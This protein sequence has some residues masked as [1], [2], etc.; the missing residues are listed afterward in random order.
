MS[1]GRVQAQALGQHDRLLR[2][3]VRAG[4]LAWIIE[5]VWR[6]VDG[7]LQACISRDELLTNI[8]LFWFTQSITSSMRLYREAIGPQSTA[9]PDILKHRC[10]V[11]HPSHIVLQVWALHSTGSVSAKLEGSCSHVRHSMSSQIVMHSLQ[12]CTGCICMPVP[13]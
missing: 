2:W 4:L 9:M 12:I 11:E 8:S 7:E 5:K 3:A 1:G 13:S 6:W 10:K